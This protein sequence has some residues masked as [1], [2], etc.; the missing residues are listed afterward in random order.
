MND[1]HIQDIPK[2]HNQIQ[3]KSDEIG[4]TMPSDLYVG[5]FLKTLI[6]S[7]P[8]SRILE[9]GTG[10]GLSLSWMIDGMDRDSHL[11]TVDNDPELIEI[12][13]SF[14]GNDKRL[15][16]VCQDGAEWILNY[17]GPK[18]DLIFADAW[19]GKYGQLVETLN[20]LRVGG[21]YVIDDMIAQPNWPEG[22]DKNVSDLVGYLEKREDLTL[23]KMNWSTGII[24]AVKNK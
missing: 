1:S 3:G 5:T 8:K 20:M 10:I 17:S 14:F 22:H 21:F 4:F 18:F 24:L 15:S 23:T 7:K 13:K 12:A 6:S 16:I 19:P 2:V 11:T 9:L